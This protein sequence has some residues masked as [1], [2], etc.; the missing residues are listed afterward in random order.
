MR[1]AACTL[2]ADKMRPPPHRRPFSATMLTRIRLRF[3]S[4]YLVR[5]D[6]PVLVDTGGPGEVEKLLAALRKAGVDPR[7]LSLILLTHGHAYHA[8][9]AAALQRMTGAPVPARARCTAVSAARSPS[10]SCARGS[11][12][13]STATAS[14]SGRSAPPFPKPRC[15]RGLATAIPQ[16]CHPEC[17]RRADPSSHGNPAAAEGSMAGT[18]ARARDHLEV[19]RS[20]PLL[21]ATALDAIETVRES[22]DPPE[23]S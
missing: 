18:R 21:P 9:N 1:P 20:G 12:A 22:M 16:E 13:G 3:S 17:R 2:P 15:D 7:D 4:A 5:G 8:G 10:R 19:G 23:C 6:R 11:R 14:A